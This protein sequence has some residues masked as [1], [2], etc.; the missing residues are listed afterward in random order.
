MEERDNGEIIYQTSLTTRQGKRTSD[1]KNTRG[2][3]LWRD[4]IGCHPALYDWDKLKK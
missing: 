4:M 2:R 3:K 1:L